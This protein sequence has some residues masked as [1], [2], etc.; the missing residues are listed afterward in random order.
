MSANECLTVDWR[1]VGY[2]DGVAGYSGDRI[3]QYR[4]ACAKHRVTPD[5]A[6]YQSGRDQGLR[7]FC[8]P[9]NGFRIGARGN[10]YNGVCPADLD[11]A[12]T[13]A[14]QSGRQLN[15]LRNRVANASHQLISMHEELKRIDEDLIKIAADILDPKTNNEERAQLLLDTKRMAE[16]RGKLKADIPQ[17]EKDLDYYQRELDDYRATL[18]Y[19]E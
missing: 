18:A 16:R 10:G 2:E 17:I 1:T 5:L 9:A 6:Q 13:S 8:K 3:G 12:F 14:F 11:G 15:T 19:V 7:E 4:K